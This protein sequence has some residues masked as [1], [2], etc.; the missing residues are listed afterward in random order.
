MA[1]EEVEIM[2]IKYYKVIIAVVLV[3]GAVIAGY[4]YGKKQYNAGYDKGYDIGYKD[5]YEERNMLASKEKPAV[6]TVTETKVVYKEIPY[7]GT[8]VQVHTEK[9]V[10]TV[11]LNGKE[12]KIEQKTATADLAVKT[13]T[14]VKLKLPEKRWSAGIG[15]DGK[16][17]AYMLKTP[18]KVGKNTD[19]LGMWVAGTKGKVM[20]GISIS[21]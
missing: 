17:V 19:N 11:S 9:P 4:M 15:T 2:I 13:E 6:Q 10:V 21:F 16:N 1:A 12:Q 20:G 14:N 7:N 8:D 5:G 3:I 18:L